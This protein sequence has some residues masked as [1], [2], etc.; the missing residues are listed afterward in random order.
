M[1]MGVFIVLLLLG[2]GIVLLGIGQLRQGTKIKNIEK[3]LG[4]KGE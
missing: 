4:I 1:D 3:L 2:I